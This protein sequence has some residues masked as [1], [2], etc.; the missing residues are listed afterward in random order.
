LQVREDILS[1]IATGGPGMGTRI[2]FGVLSDAIERIVKHVGGAPE[3]R[4]RWLEQVG[5]DCARP[6]AL[7]PLLLTDA[8]H[9]NREGV[10][11]FSTTR[12][13]RLSGLEEVCSLSADIPPEI[14]ALRRLVGE[15]AGLLRTVR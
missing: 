15:D 3:R 12:P 13:D 5:S 11:L 6:E 14:V 1:R 8:L 2:V 7:A 10:V 4:R 9:A